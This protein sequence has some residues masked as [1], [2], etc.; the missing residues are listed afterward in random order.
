MHFLI[1]IQKLKNRHENH[2][3]STKKLFDFLTILLI[4]L[5]ENYKNLSNYEYR[6]ILEKIKQLLQT[7]DENAIT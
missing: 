1:F 7:L 3:E 2:E 4:Y 6:N 5:N